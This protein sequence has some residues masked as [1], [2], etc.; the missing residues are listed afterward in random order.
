MTVLIESDD[1]ML[2][3][4][5]RL[6]DHEA[7]GE[8]YDRHAQASYATA[9]RVVSEHDQAEDVVHDAF[10]AAWQTIDRLDMTRG[11]LRAWLLT[12]VRLTAVDRIR[13]RPTM[14]LTTANDW[15]PPHTSRIRADSTTA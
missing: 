5:I 4:R 12:I 6:G 3:G 7:L 2:A 1:A 8:L 11:S 14:D 9:I 15:S 10:V 13:G